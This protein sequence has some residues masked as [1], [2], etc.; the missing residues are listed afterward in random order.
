MEES[1]SLGDKM[2]SGWEK[3]KEGAES[4]W[5]KTKEGAENIKDKITGN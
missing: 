4:G 1:K 2:K 5:E 3:T